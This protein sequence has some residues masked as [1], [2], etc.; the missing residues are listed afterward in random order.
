MAGIKDFFLAIRY[1]FTRG[2]SKQQSF[3]GGDR[4]L[5]LGRQ[6][7]SFSE[8]YSDERMPLE[9][10]FGI[11]WLPVL[12]RYA[13][14][15]ADTSLAV[16]NI[17]HLANTQYQVNF[18]VASVSKQ[19][20]LK[21]SLD[22]F[23]KRIRIHNL[24]NSLIRQMA[25]NGALSAEL[26]LQKDLRAVEQV[27]L[28]NPYTI[29]FFSKKGK[30]LPYQKTAL[31]Y[32]ALHLST[33][34]YEA[35]SNDNDSPYGIPPML[36]A[37]EGIGIERS[38]LKSFQKIA[39]KFGLFGFLEVLLTA[40][41]KKAGESEE[42]YWQRCEQLI[43]RARPQVEKNISSG[44]AL[45]F[46][47]SHQFK[48][49]GGDTDAKNAKEMMMMAD[50]I[51]MAGLKQDPNLLG[52]QQSRA[53]TFGRVLL[54]IFTAKITSYQEIVASFLEKMFEMHLLLNGTTERLEVKFDKPILIDEK[55]SRE[56]E[57]L[58]I[59]NLIKLYEKGIISL[60]QLAQALGYEAAINEKIL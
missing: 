15:N 18:K 53:E 9:A 6:S 33:Y 21:A 41:P 4:S 47:D 58:Q 12:Q 32:Q 49:T 28:V 5:P 3:V 42:A 29:R 55:L 26:V 14:F 59:D 34:H 13:V 27:A 24:I 17:V 51:K 31:S 30:Y 38:L 22:D 52:R 23:A 48:L 50:I 2:Q 46:K 1:I 57:S 25:I 40:P 43:E 10:T 60:P 20:K 19:K 39:D 44:Y 11:D 54:T 7:V 56:A 36:S 16:D 37:L 45:G 35:L 8:P